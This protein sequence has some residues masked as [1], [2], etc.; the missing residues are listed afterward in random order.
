MKIVY[1]IIAV[2][3][4]NS[5]QGIL[6]PIFHRNWDLVNP[7][8]CGIQH[9]KKTSHNTTFGTPVRNGEYPWV[10]HITVQVNETELK[11][12][13]DCYKCREPR[14]ITNCMGTIITK[15]YVLTASSCFEIFGNTSV[16]PKSVRVRAGLVGMNILC[17]IYSKCYSDNDYLAQSVFFYDHNAPAE[18]GR[19][20]AL[21]EVS[22]DFYFHEYVAPI[23]LE[24]NYLL[25]K[26]YGAEKGIRV[27]GW[28]HETV[29]VKINEGE[30][31]NLFYSEATIFTEEENDK[32]YKFLPA[33][34]TGVENYLSF[35]C[36]EGLPHQ[37]Q[38]TTDVGG[39]FV[40]KKLVKDDEERRFYLYGILSFKISVHYPPHQGTVDVYTKVRNYFEWI[41]DTI[42]G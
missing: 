12:T 17:G 35:F 21:I 1:N 36:V 5:V 27:S 20:I 25:N 15:R 26:D 10:V 6:S 38:L 24:H 41:L 18:E 31:S 29:R 2:I 9:N 37:T 39:P 33:K 42:D 8:D 30:Y 7:G 40:V 16:D 28:N 11:T 34:F 32:I 13:R 19:N 4:I 14:K 3:C 22:R 23:C